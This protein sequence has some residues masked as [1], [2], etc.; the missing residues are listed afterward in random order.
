MVTIIKSKLKHNL[1]NIKDNSNPDDEI[2][3]DNSNDPDSSQDTSSQPTKNPFKAS[4]QSVQPL[5]DFI[6]YASVDK[7]SARIS[8]DIN[9]SE[10]T[11]TDYNRKVD[12]YNI[13]KGIKVFAPNTGVPFTLAEDRKNNQPGIVYASYSH[14]SNSPNDET[15]A[16]TIMN[17]IENVVSKGNPLNARTN[18]VFVA[19]ITALYVDELNNRGLAIVYNPPKN[20]QLDD[21]QNNS[22]V[23]K[24]DKI[25]EDL[26]NKIDFNKLDTNV[27]W[28]N[29]A[30]ATCQHTNTLSPTK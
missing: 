4:G 9:R 17:M 14:D 12:Y 30:Q 20:I 11:I 28:F 18:N 10:K 15:L 25:F 27:P 16:L 13:D 1:M 24:A 26:K 22:E 6:I 2:I 7:I 21:L 3:I 29:A 8:H 19:R 5:D 23:E